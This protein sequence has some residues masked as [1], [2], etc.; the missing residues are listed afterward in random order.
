M[1]WKTS[2]QFLLTI[3]HGLKQTM[4]VGRFHISW[5]RRR[6]R[7][8]MAD[9]WCLQRAG[10]RPSHIF[11]RCKR[12]HLQFC[13]QHYVRIAHR[14]SSLITAIKVNNI[15]PPILLLIFFFWV[16]S[17]VCLVSICFCCSRL[18]TSVCDL[19]VCFLFLM[20]PEIRFLQVI[21]CVNSCREWVLFNNSFGKVTQFGNLYMLCQT[22]A[23]YCISTWE[24]SMLKL[25]LPN[26][27]EEVMAQEQDRTDAV[28]T[29]LSPLII[30]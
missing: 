15:E 18:C 8:F 7:I 21:H 9:L 26:K 27:G 22:I 3:L 1:V 14:Q 16:V 23:K 17:H 29:Y 10:V 11:R 28:L 25:S 6:R 2:S 13:G 5:R 12:T 24:P 19:A 30:A 20:L 4:I